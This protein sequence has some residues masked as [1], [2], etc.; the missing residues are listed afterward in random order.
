MLEMEKDLVTGW[1]GRLR[2]SAID[3]TLEEKEAGSLYM[4]WA[5]AHSII[6]NGFKLLLNLL[7]FTILRIRPGTQ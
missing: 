4:P 3:S 7:Y 5:E 1:I 6:W 2:D